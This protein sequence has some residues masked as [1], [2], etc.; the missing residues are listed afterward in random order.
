VSGQ[1]HN[2]ATLPLK[3]EAPV[4]IGQETGWIP[5]LFWMWWQREKSMPLS[6]IEPQSPN[7][8]PV[9]THFFSKFGN[10]KKNN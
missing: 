5:E 8:Q 10:G 7:P 1:L 3:K 2:L 9:T 4:F 6:K